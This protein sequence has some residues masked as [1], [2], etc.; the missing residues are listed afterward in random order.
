MTTVRIQLVGILHGLKH[1]RRAPVTDRFHLLVV[2]LCGSNTQKLSGGVFRCVCVRA[3]CGWASTSIWDSALTQACAPSE[4][5]PFGSFFF[6]WQH[7]SQ[8][9]ITETSFWEIWCWALSRCYHCSLCLRLMHAAI[10]LHF[11]CHTEDLVVAVLM[12]M[13]KVLRVVTNPQSFI[14]QLCSSA[15][16][17]GRS[18]CLPAVVFNV[19]LQ[20]T[21]VLF[22]SHR[23]YQYHIKSQKA[24]FSV[25]KL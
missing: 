3:L 16:I 4:H 18:L 7:N 14:T 21:T 8:H 23:C 2:E 20:P 17:Y 6:F 15:Q 19:V 5:I 22:N 11:S 24:A 9:V 1:G 10:L 25:K 13:W 12:C